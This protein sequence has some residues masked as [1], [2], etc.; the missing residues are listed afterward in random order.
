[1]SRH[2]AVIDPAVSRAELDCFNRLARVSPLPLNYYLPALYGLETFTEN[3]LAGFIL[4]GSAS[5]PTEKSPWQ[6]KLAARLQP[7]LARGLPALGLC[8]GHQFLAHLAGAR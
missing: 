8:F 5:S 7:L 3:E 1:M 6:N 2:I 4:L